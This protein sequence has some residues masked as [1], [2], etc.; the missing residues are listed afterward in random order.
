MTE[1]TRRKIKSFLKENS[2]KKLTLNIGAGTRK[3]YEFFP[4]QIRIDISKKSDIDILCDAHNLCF[5]DNVFDSVL[6]SEVLEHL[7]EPQAA[8][9]EIYRVM[10]KNGKLLLTTVFMYPYHNSPW[11]Y[12]R[13]TKDGLAYLLRRWS[14]IKITPY[15]N[16]FEFIGNLI[17]CYGDNDLKIMGIR[18]VLVW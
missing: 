7:R 3:L 11:D 6:C 16:R 14:K 4:H 18:F 15:C 17:Q 13:F 1:I 8:L 12:F 2:T 5:K 10:R 9:D